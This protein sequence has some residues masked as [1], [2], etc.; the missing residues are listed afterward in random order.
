MGIAKYYHIAE[1]NFLNSFVYF[2]DT[3]ASSL[4][5]GLVVFVFTRLWGVIY[6]GNAPIE[7]FTIVMMLWYFVMTESITTSHGKV[8]E[9]IGNE[10]INGEIANHLSK[11]Y[12]Y[13]A[14]KYSMTIG[15]SLF[16]F[17][18]T[19]LVGSAVLLIFLR[20]MEIALYSIPFI[21]IVILLAITLHFAMIAFLGVFAF[22]FEDAKA[23]HFIYQKVI[24]S[25]GGMFL[26]L[27]FFP[28]WLG[29]ISAALP[30][31]Y[32]AYHPAKLF[33]DFNW[34]D[35]IRVLIM[36]SWWILFFA[37]LIWILYS[38]YTRRLSVNGG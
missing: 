36:E 33:V 24:F 8:L 22:W 26:P 34:P 9:E 1:T 23:L 17:F 37:V 16:K 6:D 38:L 21:A 13:I 15:K 29:K 20:P 35:F 14:Y 12:N 7:G 2:T 5:I 10:V 32:V 19:F 28:A 25:I 18:L 31:S 11:P 3:I 27:D 4:F 30:F